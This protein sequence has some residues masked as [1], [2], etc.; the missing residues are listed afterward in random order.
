MGTGA[1]GRTRCEGEAPPRRFYTRKDI[2][3]P[4]TFSCYRQRYRIIDALILIRIYAL[5]ISMQRVNRVYPVVFVMLVPSNKTPLN[6]DQK[7]ESMGNCYHQDF[8]SESCTT[9][10]FPLHA[11]LLA[12]FSPPPPS[13]PRNLSSSPFDKPTTTSALQVLSVRILIPDPRPRGPRASA[14]GVVGSQAAYQVYE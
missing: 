8:P 1:L 5:K 13:V 14:N 7:G 3:Y 10:H 4:S 11:Q 12:P 6:P 9:A 2:G